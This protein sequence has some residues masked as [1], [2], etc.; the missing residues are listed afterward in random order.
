MTDSSS[1][2]PLS[3]RG[4]RERSAY[5]AEESFHDANTRLHRTLRH[6]RLSPA[7]ERGRAEMRRR[8]LAQARRGPALEVGCGGGHETAW[9]LAQGAAHIDAIDVSQSMLEEARRRNAA[10]G[11]ATFTLHD[12]NVPWNGTYRAIF[13]RAVLHHVDFQEVLPRLYHDNLL[14]GGLMAFF[15]PLGANPLMR[16][17]WG[18][19]RHLH[20]PDERP[21]YP[22]DLRWIRTHLG[23]LEILP[24]DLLQIPVSV[25]SS[26][27]FKRV[28]NPLT[29]FAD[30]IDRRLTSRIP[31]LS[32]YCKS[33]VF[34]IHKP[35]A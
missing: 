9:F 14:P 26:L 13:G 28:E 29:R 22:R 31:A 15:E 2:A 4:R 16:L 1:S 18:A 19:S 10:A 30:G 17:Y 5:D 34:F 24:V 33:A 12:I 8:V 20:T 27:V 35:A 32:P 7:A 25:L 23:D 6:V 21:F 11:R 3:A